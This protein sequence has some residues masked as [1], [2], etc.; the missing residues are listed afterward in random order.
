MYSSEI[1]FSHSFLFMNLFTGLK[2]LTN[3]YRKTHPRLYINYTYSQFDLSKCST[4]STR[5]SGVDNEYTVVTFFHLLRSYAVK[6]AKN[7]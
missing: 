4:L 2:I 7:C 6:D 3:S 5:I 1:K